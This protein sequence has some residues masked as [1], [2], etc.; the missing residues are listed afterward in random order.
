[1]NLG[2]DWYRDNRENDGFTISPEARE[3]VLTRLLELNNER[4]NGEVRK[5]FHGG[6]SAG[7]AMVKTPMRVKEKAVE[8]LLGLQDPWP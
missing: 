6:E 3:E 2:H 8:A 5:G 4:I 7:R 1:M